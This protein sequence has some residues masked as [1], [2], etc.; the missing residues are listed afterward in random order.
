MN[1]Y[2][3]AWDDIVGGATASWGI[4][5]ECF[6]RKYGCDYEDGKVAPRIGRKSLR[7]GHSSSPI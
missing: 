5:L 6:C 2:N 7:A 1:E 3:Q 4:G